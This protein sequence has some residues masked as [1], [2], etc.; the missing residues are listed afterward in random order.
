[1]YLKRIC[2]ETAFQK[3]DKRGSLQKNCIKTDDNHFLLLSL[4]KMVYYAFVAKL[5]FGFI[6]SRS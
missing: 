1:M 3:T 6:Y 4:R 2:M 5:C